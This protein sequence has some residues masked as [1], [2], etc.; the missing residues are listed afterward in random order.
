MADHFL[1]S[2]RLL[3]E[4]VA[5]QPVTRRFRRLGGLDTAEF[6]DR[7]EARLETLDVVGQ[8]DDV[9]EYW[10][11]LGGCIEKTLD[12]LAPYIT[13]SVR[14]TSPNHF[15]LSPQAQTAKEHRRLY[16]V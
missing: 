4:S 6:F 2:C 5:T 14:P 9:N 16:Q 15:T 13:V 7:L 1:V 10:E 12:E 3:A 8:V 11:G